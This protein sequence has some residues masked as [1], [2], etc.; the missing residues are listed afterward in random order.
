MSKE[1]YEPFNLARL[2]L[3]KPK[4]PEPE[5]EKA[6]RFVVPWNRS[7]KLEAPQM[8][9]PAPENDGELTEE[10][11]AALIAEARQDWRDTMLSLFWGYYHGGNPFKPRNALNRHYKRHMAVAGTVSKAK[12]FALRLLFLVGVS[13]F[14][15]ISAYFMSER[16]SWYL[17]GP[18]GLIVIGLLWGFSGVPG[19]YHACFFKVY[20]HERADYTD[21]TQVTR[22][23]EVFLS[24]L[25]FYD[26]PAIWRGNDLQDAWT[27]KG[28]VGVLVTGMD[29]I[30]PYKGLYA[31]ESRWEKDIWCDYVEGKMV[32]NFRTAEEFYDLDADPYMMTGSTVVMRR[33]FCRELQSSGDDFRLLERGGPSWYDGR[34]GLIIGGVGVAAGLLAMALG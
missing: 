11:V 13:L 12:G 19:K 24:R 7:K 25:G 29:K 21:V 18:A 4:P 5:K 10:R 3:P 31:D 8:R 32:E 1:P 33:V 17:L 27:D 30:L 16:L 14:V 6:P 20:V 22:Y 26:K 9:A 15:G 34:I 28:A 2:Q 23:V